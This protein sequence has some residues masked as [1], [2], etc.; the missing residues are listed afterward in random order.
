M[1]YNIILAVFFLFPAI[2]L[3]Q[4]TTVDIKCN[5]LDSG[6]VI[7]PGSSALITFDVTAGSGAGY[8]V[9]VWIVLKTQSGYFTYDG[10]GPYSGWN[11]GLDNAYFT[12]P[13]ADMTGTALDGP[14][15]AGE[16]IAYI[17][18]D[19]WPDGFLTLS[20]I[21]TSDSVDFSVGV[22][23]GMA[24]IPGGEFEMGDHSGVGYPDELP[25]HTV[26]IDAFA[27]DVFEVTNQQY[28]DYLNSAWSQGGLIEV[29]NGVVYKAGSGTSYPYCSTTSAPTGYPDY[30]EH[31][32]ITWNGS[33][34][35][36]VSGKEDHPMV[37][38]S[39][40]GA[41]AYANWRSAEDGLPACYD[42]DAWECTFGAGGYRL[43]TEAEWEKAARGA[44]HN[45]YYRYP[46]G[47]SIDGSNANYW[48][49]GDPYETGPY[50]WTTP[51]GYYDGNQT[52]P[53]TD[54]ANGYG[55]YDMSGNVWEW[56]NDWYDSGYYSLSP[57]DNPHGPTNGTYRVFRGGSWDDD[58]SRMRCAV[59]D[60][61]YPDYRYYSYGFR[62][63][64]D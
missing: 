61:H 11:R 56:C 12:G 43:P 26:Y 19:A 23:S 3:A 53:G 52:P 30:G 60:G 2:G 33:T 42:L 20:C 34:F 50:P 57:Y 16:Y 39:W 17:A 7:N 49:S 9:D 51:V 5:G 58:A 14:P 28:C 44:E 64:L 63:A 36:I 22:P 6:V 1:R 32:R 25:V 13:L 35:G 37:L 8:A 21:Y 29:T 18:V 10:F 45:P 24:F 54:M 31:S 47:D 46:W 41:V 27:M 40:Y 62:L 4:D 59:R 48:N 15:P 55:L 38:V